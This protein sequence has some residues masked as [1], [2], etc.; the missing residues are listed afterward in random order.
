M[1][2]IINISL[3][4]GVRLVRTKSQGPEITHA[5]EETKMAGVGNML[6]SQQIFDRLVCIVD[7]LCL[8]PAP[9]IEP[10]TYISPQRRMA[11]KKNPQ[12]NFFCNLANAQCYPSIRY[13]PVFFKAQ[14]FWYSLLSFILITEFEFIWHKPYFCLLKLLNSDSHLPPSSLSILK[15]TKRSSSSHS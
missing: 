11:G 9:K 12:G 10:R 13:V 8:F 14:T 6:L 4:S 2:N 7:W 3:K 15:S 1:F 5:T